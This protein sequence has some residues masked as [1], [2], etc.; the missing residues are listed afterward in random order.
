MHPA[1]QGAILC[2]RQPN[3]VGGKERRVHAAAWRKRKP[4]PAEAGV[5]WGWYEVAPD[6]ASKKKRGN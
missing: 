6:G 5:P 3:K 4:L 2:Q 1:D